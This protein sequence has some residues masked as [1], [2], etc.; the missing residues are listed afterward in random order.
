MHAFGTRAAGHERSLQDFT[1]H[2][3]SVEGYQ[4]VHDMKAR[5]YISGLGVFG[6]V[7]PSASS[8]SGVSPYSYTLN[9]PINNIDPDGEDVVPI[10]FPDYKISVNGQ[11]VSGL[12]HAGVL[13]IDNVTGLTK[14][15]EYDRYDKA[16]HGIVRNKSIPNV[17]IGSDGKPTP[18]SLQKV[19]AAISK[20]SGHGGRIEAAY[21]ESD[22]FDAMNS[23]AQERMS[24]N[25]NSKRTPYSITSNNCGTFMCDVAKQDPAVADQFPWLFDPRPNSVITELRE[26]FTPLDYNPTPKPKPAPKPKPTPKPKPDP[27]QA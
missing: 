5:Q 17:K 15:Y 13:I 4:G 3:L 21:I 18:A 24:Q 8:Y 11:K 6:G 23:Y 2:D 12:G 25:S 14:Y 26:E 22:E 9:D 1:G 7:D 27:D 10:V 16:G 20:K 19:L